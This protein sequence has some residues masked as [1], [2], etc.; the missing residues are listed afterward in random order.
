MAGKMEKSYGYIAA[1]V[2]GAMTSLF[3]ST[4]IIYTLVTLGGVIML[5]AVAFYAYRYTKAK[6]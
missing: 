5:A 6:E 2:A 4:R 1:F 3:V